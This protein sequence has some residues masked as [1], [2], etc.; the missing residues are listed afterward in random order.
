VISDYKI[1]VGSG[2]GEHDNTEFNAKFLKQSIEKEDLNSVLVFSSSHA[3]SREI[4]LAFKEIFSGPHKLILTRSG[5]SSRE[6]TA[7]I[8]LLNT[9][10]PVI[11]FNVRVFSI[12]SDLVPLQAIMLNGDK[13][14]VIDIVQSVSRC[15]RLH[16]EK[17]HGTL[18]VPCLVTED[19]LE[20]QGTFMRL[21]TFLSA[22]GSVDS[23][24][25]EE[26][27]ARAMN[28]E[29]GTRRIYTDMVIGSAVEEVPGTLCED[30]E[31]R[32]FDS[33]GRSTNFSPE[34]RFELLREFCLKENRLPLRNEVYRELKIGCFIHNLLNRKQCA[35]T[36]DSWIQSLLSIENIRDSLQARIDNINDEEAHAKRKIPPVTRFEV[37][38]KF[39]E[40]NTR[41]P[42]HREM[43]ENI[44][45]GEFLGTLLS[46]KYYAN[47]RD[48]WIQSLLSI[49]SIRD[50]FQARLDARNDEE[51]RA[52]RKISPSTRF[53][54]LVKF[55]EENTRLP[56]RS[57]MYENIPVGKFMDNLLNKKYYVNIRDSWIQSLLSIESIRDEFQARLDARNDEEAH[58][59]RKIPPV[60]RFEALVKFCEENTRLPLHREMYENIPVGQFIET[61]LS[62]KYYANTRDSWIQSLLSIESIRDSLQARLDVRND[63]EAR[64]RRKISSATRF[65]T[66]VKFCEENTRLPL[67]K[68]IYENIP[69]GEFL[70]GLLSGKRYTATRDSWI[71]S[72]LS[73]QDIA[74]ELQ[75]RLNTRSWYSNTQ[76]DTDNENSPELSETEIDE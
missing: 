40:E 26:V 47:T 72:L 57:E 66:L 52:K 25:R 31:L 32:I 61:L 36:R 76:E 56:L 46:G 21:R 49:E 29:G 13:G 35:D 8:Q 41:L 20:G 65:E 24:I 58:A 18:L 38:V 4:Y 63:V 75:T 53:E 15:L 50:E 54:I 69:V 1:I 74:E 3:Q 2:T 42:L 48:S 7:V 51:A 68:E 11:I 10:K 73:N 16:S 17:D 71:Q 39:C 9:G 27:I 30:F 55:C 45:V 19:T 6:K 22:L 43:Y 5:I 12:G 28:R 60:T 37:L 34:I 14:S 59:K 44:P 33:M 70:N 62:K 64:T 67:Y 23:A